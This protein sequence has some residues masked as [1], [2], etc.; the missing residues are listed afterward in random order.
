ML[1]MREIVRKQGGDSYILESY[2]QAQTL[3]F[4]RQELSN[5]ITDDIAIEELS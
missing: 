3:Q 2:G 4:H 5:T 1:N